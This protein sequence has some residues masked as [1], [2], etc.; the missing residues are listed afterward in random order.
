M[1]HRADKTADP[2]WAAAYELMM[3]RLDEGASLGGLKITRDELHD[4]YSFTV[5]AAAR[6]EP[7]L[8]P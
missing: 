2:E 1:P 6:L 5:D 8:E 3:A 7:L 4:R